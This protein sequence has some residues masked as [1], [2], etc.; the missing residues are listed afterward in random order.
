MPE[1]GTYAR[2]WSLFKTSARILR[3]N[4]VLLLF[5][6]SGTVFVTV[7]AA[8]FFGTDVFFV[9]LLD[10]PPPTPLQ[11]RVG[12]ALV[13]LVVMFLA[14]F[15][16]V[17][18]THETFMAFD[19]E[20]VFLTRGFAFAIHRLRSILLW[21]LF[22]GLVGLVIRSLEQRFDFFGRLVIKLVGVVWSVSSV[23]VI[24]VMIRESSPNPIELLK[25]S[26]STI[27]KSWGEALVGYAGIGLGLTVALLLFLVAIGTSGYALLKLLGEGWAPVFN[28]AWVAIFVGSILV[29]SALDTIFRSAL[30]VY[31]TEGVAPASYDKNM[32]DAAWKVK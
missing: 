28:V 8:L 21:S 24:P 9:D 11:G 25:K 23:F 18:F 3:D 19:G 17:A 22:A 16:N 2:S 30:Y 4:K 7:F 20:P 29:S 31:A 32:L 13:Y 27:R 6:L 12:F 14:T 10:T 26:A 15:I 1:Q 5:P